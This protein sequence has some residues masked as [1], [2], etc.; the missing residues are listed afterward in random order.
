M[1]EYTE[2]VAAFFDSTT[3]HLPIES[4][5]FPDTR[6]RVVTKSAM[7]DAIESVVKSVG[8]RLYDVARRLRFGGHSCRVAGSGF[9]A[10]QGMAHNKL[11]K[12]HSPLRSRRAPGA[13][14]FL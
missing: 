9:W 10:S 8:E 14:E 13:R 7:V 2:K 5:A 11:P 3:D 12:R 4:P 1:S 6:G